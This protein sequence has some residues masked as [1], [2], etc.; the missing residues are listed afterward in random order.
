MPGEH[1]GKFVGRPKA[2][3]ESKDALT[4]RM[5]AGGE[6]VTTIAKTLGVSRATVYRVL[7][8]TSSDLA[9]GSRLRPS[10]VQAKRSVTPQLSVVL[11]QR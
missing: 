7:M 6:P 1:G 8:V 10:G 2:L 3:D 11:R 9:S 4:R 5:L